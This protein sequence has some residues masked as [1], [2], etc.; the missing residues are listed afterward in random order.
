[1]HHLT[2]ARFTF[3]R[4]A[5]VWLF[6][7][8]VALTPAA[9]Q[10]L[11]VRPVGTGTQQVGQLR[12]INADGTGD[13]A[14]AVPF[15][16]VLGPVAAPDGTQFALSAVDPARPNQIS[17]NV[18]TVNRATGATQNAS[19]F[20]DS[21]DPDTLKYTY[22]YA[23]YKA[24]SPDGTKVAVNSIYRSGGG[25]ASETGTPILQIFPSDGSSGSLAL[26]HADPFLDGTHHGGE[27][28]DWSPVDQDLIV[29]PIKWDAP[30]LSGGGVGEATAIFL[31]EPVTG[32]GN[33]RQL[34]FPRA[35]ATSNISTGEVTLWGEHDY[36]PKFSPN[37][38]GVAYVRSF[39]LVSNLRVIPD[40]YV[41]TLRIA[42][43]D[44]TSDVPIAS[45]QPGF[46]VTSVAWSPDGTQLIFD[47]G[48]QAFSN[49]YPLSYAVPDSDSVYVVN[50]DGSGLRQFLAAP[51]GQPT[52]APAPP[53]PNLGNISTRLSV[54]TSDD[55]LI[56]GFIITGTGDKN[57]LVRAIGPSLGT[58]GVVGA[59]ADPTL[60]LHDQTGATIASND[61]WQDTQESEIEA[62]TIPPTDAHESAIVRRLT[63]GSYTAIVRGKNN[64]TGVGLVEAYGLDGTAKLANISSR[65]LV[66]TG[67]NVMIG[68]F[69][70][71]NTGVPTE[72]IVRAIG[73][74]L[75]GVANPLADPTLELHD[76]NGAT[77][78]SNDNWKDTQQ[79]EIEAT[80]IPP[81][82]DRESAIVQTLNAGAYT[83]VV[84][85]KNNTTGVALVEAY[86]LQ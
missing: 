81:T 15:P 31:A 7:A 36:Q 75:T 51:A 53:P 40:P 19:N 10:I 3:G 52:W 17:R 41:E 20:L 86:N 47:I 24:F 62:T 18:F 12:Q 71:L 34:T 83:A 14:V 33:I 70:V 42:S 39:Q 30:L 68:G 35:D 22:V 59:L 57:V 38:T 4:S 27:G 74:S 16:D 67:D 78:A 69:I 85:G 54:G 45:F 46:Y 84:R 11:Y 9:A 82:D 79:N 13:T 77:V 80:T 49:G 65:G 29:A 76:S 23:F 72:V 58:V 61:N 26:V 6:C 44:G 32:A 50:V 63:P 73:P 21:L 43:V 37:G 1:M 56:G 2:Y 55:V 48:P 5:I 60:E 28:V 25:G 8:L 64:T 66:E